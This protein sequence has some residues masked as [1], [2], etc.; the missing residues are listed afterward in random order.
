MTTCLR[1]LPSLRISGAEPPLLMYAFV[2]YLGANLPSFYL[3]IMC[4]IND[5]GMI[6][7]SVSSVAEC[8]CLLRTGSVLGLRDP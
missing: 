5:V 3:Y 2:T 7:G 4:D 8:S 1:V 6:R